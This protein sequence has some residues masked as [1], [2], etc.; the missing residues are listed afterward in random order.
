MTLTLTP[1]G[2]KL[3]S[4]FLRDHP[5]LAELGARVVSKTPPDRATPWVR[6]TQLDAG[7]ATRDPSDHLV[8]FFLQLDCYAGADGGKPQASLLTRTARAALQ[9]IAQ[10]SHADAVVTGCRI[11]GAARVPDTDFEPA[12]ERFVLTATVWAHAA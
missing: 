2:E 4:D 9:T 10:A 7:Q 6:V 8:E 11:S 12:R 3:V 5:D 1:D